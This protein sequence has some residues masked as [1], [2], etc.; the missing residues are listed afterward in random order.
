MGKQDHGFR[1]RGLFPTDPDSYSNKS[2]FVTSKGSRTGFLALNITTARGFFKF[3]APMENELD[4]SKMVTHVVHWHVNTN[5][6]VQV[7][8][9]ETVAAHMYRMGLL[10][11]L[12]SHKQKR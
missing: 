10:G 12:L 1:A 9:P 7:R 8:A 4:P 3:T 2:G 5:I 6:P 11:L